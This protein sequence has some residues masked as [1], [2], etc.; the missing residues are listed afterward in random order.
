MPAGGG[1]ATSPG[2]A[3][4]GERLRGCALDPQPAPAVFRR[5]AA[6][7]PARWY[8]PPMKRLSRRAALLRGLAA[9]A[10]L[11]AASAPAAARAQFKCDKSVQYNSTWCS[12]SAIVSIKPADAT[13]T[14]QDFTKELERRCKPDWDRFESCRT[15]ADRFETMLV[16]SCKARKI[17]ARSC[18]SWG[19]A[20]A[21]ALVTRCERGRYTY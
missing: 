9:L 16:R 14:C 3:E 7:A 18:Q 19:D 1:Q 5:P 10:L 12:Q 8:D 4:V 13:A 21:A 17:P 11:A 2:D 15:F 20:Y 6:A